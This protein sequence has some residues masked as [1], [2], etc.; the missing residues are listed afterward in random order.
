MLL[1]QRITRST[2]FSTGN[3][4]PYADIKVL[5]PVRERHFFVW[6]RQKSRHRAEKAVFDENFLITYPPRI[7]VNIIGID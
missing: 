1:I 2:R 5:F 7:I 4:P 6:A 3:I